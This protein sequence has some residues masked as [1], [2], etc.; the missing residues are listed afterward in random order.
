MLTSNYQSSEGAKN[1]KQRRREETLGADVNEIENKLMIETISEAK[2][3]YL[4]R[5]TKW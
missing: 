1:L 2:V 3:G 4:T 5:L